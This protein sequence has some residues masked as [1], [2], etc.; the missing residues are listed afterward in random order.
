MKSIKDLT[1]LNSVVG[2]IKN[3]E[4]P[5]HN[6]QRDIYQEPPYVVKVSYI[7]LTDG[8]LD[9]ELDLGNKKE[10]S[11]IQAGEFLCLL[12]NGHL[13][14]H[15][16]QTLIKMGGQQKKIMNSVLNAWYLL[17]QKVKNT[18]L[19]KPSEVHRANMIYQPREQ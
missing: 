8:S 19:I 3:I 17:E 5:R 18:P 11:L 14:T 2:K 10:I 15:T 16:I 6:T 12:H 1:S 7:V 4:K 13:K 9:I